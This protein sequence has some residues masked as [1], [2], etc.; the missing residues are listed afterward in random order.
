MNLKIYKACAILMLMGIY[1]N[2]NINKKVIVYGII[3]LF[4]GITLVPLSN[5]GV[6]KKTLTTTISEIPESPINSVNSIYKLLIITPSTFVDELKPLVSHK[7]NVGVS[8]RLV[9]LCEV[10][11]QMYWHGRDTAEKMGV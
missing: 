3:I 8:T 6:N 1:M 4:F 11:D 2:K 5:A 10:Y 7:N 9:T